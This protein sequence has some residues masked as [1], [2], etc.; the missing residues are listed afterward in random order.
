MA[1]GSSEVK[2][3]T[4]VTLISAFRARILSNEPSEKEETWLERCVMILEKIGCNIGCLFS[5]PVDDGV[6]ETH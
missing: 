2:S 5:Q 3:N 6:Q 4:S 1:R